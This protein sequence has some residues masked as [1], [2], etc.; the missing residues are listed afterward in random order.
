[1]KFVLGFLLGIFAG[2]SRE[3]WWPW[4]LCLVD[5]ITKQWVK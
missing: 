2:I 5:W 3:F 4:V 1:M